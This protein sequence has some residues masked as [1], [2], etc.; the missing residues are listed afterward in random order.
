MKPFI[1]KKRCAADP[2]ICPPL[3]ECPRQAFSF[4]ADDDEPLGGRMEIDPGRCD[5]CGKCAE[6]CCGKC[7]EM[8]PN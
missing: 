1:V 5:G 6:I 2:R 3:M 7:I 8:R 4:V